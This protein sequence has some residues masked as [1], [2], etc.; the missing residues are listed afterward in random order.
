KRSISLQSRG[1]QAFA[2]IAALTALFLVG[3]TLGRQLHVEASDDPVLS[4]MGMTRAELRAVAL[5]RAT[6]VA[7]VG[8][9][10]GIGF[11]IL[12]SPLAPLSHTTAHRALIHTGIAADWIVLGLGGLAAVVL[13]AMAAVVPAFRATRS[14]AAAERLAP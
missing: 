1:L 10:V 3:Q 7:G 11:A 2:V 5:L 13:L 8:A 9:V 14:A 12:L 6:V 4:A